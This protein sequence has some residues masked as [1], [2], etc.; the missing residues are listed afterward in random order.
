M[1]KLALLF[2]LLLW[3]V[4]EASAQCTNPY[5][6]FKQGMLLE[7]TS[8]DSKG[9]ITSKTISEIKSVA[10]SGNGL[11]AD[12]DFRLIDDKGNDISSGSYQIK[13]NNGVLQ[14]DV[15]RM[16]PQESLQVFKD[17]EATIEMTELQLPSDLQVGSS[18]PDASFMMK[19]QSDQMPMTFTFDIVNRKVESKES[20][21]TSAG[22]FECFKI[23]Y[24]VNSKIVFA[25]TK[26]KGVDYVAKG[27]G[28][29]KTETY[30]SNGKIAGYTQLTKFEE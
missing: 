5:Y 2:Y 1:K 16:I 19:T 30:K 28:T 4:S 15:S 21:T 26:M 23:T 10:K 9:K 11:N 25:N 20:I 3:L 14:I 27:V 8:F 22:T 12:I 17:M 7:M 29:V 13:C 6:N 24:D 18:L